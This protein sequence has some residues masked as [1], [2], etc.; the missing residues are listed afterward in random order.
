[1]YAASIFPNPELPPI[2]GTEPGV[3][4]LWFAVYTHARHEKVVAEEVKGMGIT[5]FLPL[6]RQ[7]RQWS[8]RR[9]I[10]DFPLFSG[11]VFVKVAPN[12]DC[13]S[14]VLRA[15]GVLGFVGPR[16]RGL[17]I[18]DEEIETVRLLVEQDLPVCAHPFLKI[19]QRVRIRGGSLNGV[20]G[21][22]VSRSG[23]QS[24]IVS[25]DAIQRSLSLRIQGYDVEPV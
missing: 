4:P 19:G 3:D 20:E 8:D 5:A 24:L 12:N 17:P 16:G 21:I 2:S 10:V 6:V 9:K 25:V 18:P 22:L 7:V 23:E 15:N 1:M 11:Y 13:R 14:R